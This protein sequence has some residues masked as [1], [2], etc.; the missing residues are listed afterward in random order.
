MKIVY[1][2]DQVY[3]HGGIEK[4]LSQK[5]CYFA[6]YCGD[7]VTILTINQN[8]RKPAYSFSER[9]KFVDLGVT[10]VSGKSYFNPKNLKKLPT[11]RILLQQALKLINPQVIISCNYGPDFYILPFVGRNIP[12]IKEFHSSRF[13]EDENISGLK[14]LILK[15]IGQWIERQYSSIVV[16]NNCEAQYYCND[17]ISVIPNPAETGGGH[18]DVTNKTILAA[19]RLAPVKNFGELIEAFSLVAQDFPDWQLH[20]YGEDYDGT[21]NKLQDLIDAKDLSAQIIFMGVTNDLKNKMQ[22]YS[23][24][25]MTSETECFP[26]VLLESLSVGLPVITYNCPTG[27]KHIVTDREDGFVVPYKNLTIFAE[28]LKKMMEDESLRK[29]MAKKGIENMNRFNINLVMQRWRTLLVSL[30]R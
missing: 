30:V 6:D 23:I 17:H 12:K 3:R 2:T 24:Y 13:F 22:G 26:M 21:Q 10:Y 5:A 25:A 4:V 16:L 27:P 19:G 20:L 18:A 29:N 14:A 9:I 8:G 28:Q 7:D 1:I 15:K 11:H